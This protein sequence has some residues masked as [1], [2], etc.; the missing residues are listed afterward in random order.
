L[1]TLAQKQVGLVLEHLVATHQILN[2]ACHSRLQPPYFLTA[3]NNP[4]ASQSL[5]QR[6]RPAAGGLQAT[7][8]ASPMTFDALPSSALSAFDESTSSVSL[9]VIVVPDGSPIATG[10][11][12]SPT[13]LPFVLPS[14]GLENGAVSTS[15]AAQAALLSPT[16]SPLMGSLNSTSLSLAQQCAPASE[17][18]AQLEYRLALL[19]LKSE[20]KAHRATLPKTS[21]FHQHAY[22]FQGVAQELIPM[23]P[24][25]D[26]FVPLD[27]APNSIMSF[28]QN[29]LHVARATPPSTQMLCSVTVTASPST[30]G[31]PLSEMSPRCTCSMADG[32]VN[33]SGGGARLH[34]SSSRLQHH[35]RCCSSLSSF[36]PSPADG[37]CTPVPAVTSP[38]VSSGERRRSMV[39]PNNNLTAVAGKNPGT[40]LLDGSAPPLLV[41][42]PSNGGVVSQPQSVSSASRRLSVERGCSSMLAALAA[43]QLL[44]QHPP[45]PHSLTAGVVSDCIDV[46]LTGSSSDFE[47]G[48]QFPLS[49]P[50]SLTRKGVGSLTCTPT[51]ATASAHTTA[52]G[53]MPSFSRLSSPTNASGRVSPATGV[54]PQRRLSFA[55]LASTAVAA[56]MPETSWP[57]QH[58]S[59]VLAQQAEQRRLLLFNHAQTNSLGGRQSSSHERTASMP[60]S[61]NSVAGPSTKHLP[62]QCHPS[63]EDATVAAGAI[64]SAS[65]N[66]NGAGTA[67]VATALDLAPHGRARSVSVDC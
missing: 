32:G 19:A 30:I 29:T 53:A 4:G 24:H 62:G 17:N 39:T 67:A 27:S 50:E 28:M 16:W 41:I 58:G 6:L 65:S 37:C 54:A 48:G 12:Q 7:P 59:S 36:P 56:S 33:G 49:S 1:N 63:V 44:Q 64:V 3:L 5:A 40:L 38:S 47:E 60:M 22:R 34:G 14:V 26:K 18:L 25:P 45:H 57:L 8:S 51:A 21:L 15:A 43:Q 10:M 20:W 35:H 13:T 11:Q 55:H 2:L 31:S 52:T 23:A 42:P 46:L 61:I 9:H 66:S